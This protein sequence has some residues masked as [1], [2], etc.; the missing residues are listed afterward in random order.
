MV[1]V[2]SY[3]YLLLMVDDPVPA[4]LTS[5]KK[6]ATGLLSLNRNII[7][8]YQEG[9]ILLNHLLEIRTTYDNI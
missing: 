3:V 9:D 2:D 1:D 6:N 5:T 7:G 4:L 8:N